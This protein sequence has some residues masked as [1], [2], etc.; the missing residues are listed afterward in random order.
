MMT[1]TSLF[2]HVFRRTKRTAY[3]FTDCFTGETE[4]K[5]LIR[6]INRWTSKLNVKKGFFRQRLLMLIKE[7]ENAEEYMYLAD[8]HGNTNQ[9]R[10]YAQLIKGLTREYDL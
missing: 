9:A 6:D 10:Y 2:K 3:L 5:R 1:V 4:L 8:S 7:I